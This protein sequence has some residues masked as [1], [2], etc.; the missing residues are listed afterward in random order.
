MRYFFDFLQRIQAILWLV[1]AANLL[2]PV[3]V[4][5]QGD[6]TVDD[7]FA[8][9]VLSDDAEELTAVAS[10]FYTVT[11]AK[12]EFSV[13]LIEQLDVPDGFSVSVFAEGLENPRIIA[14]TDEG[15]IYV[16]RQKQQTVALLADDND[17]GRADKVTDVVTG[18]KDV[19]GLAV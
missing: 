16:S 14:V 9:P 7:F 6:R 13:E 4:V 2:V 3:L 10:E 8:N 12:K 1:V 18:I 15:Y 19:H 5:A 17:D 11:P